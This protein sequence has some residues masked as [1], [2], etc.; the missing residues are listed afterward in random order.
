ML[1]NLMETGTIP[2][3]NLKMD[4]ENDCITL[5][6]SYKGGED[7]DMWKFWKYADENTMHGRNRALHAAIAK[8]KEEVAE[9]PP[10]SYIAKI[11]NLISELFKKYGM[12]KNCLRIS[13]PNGNRYYYRYY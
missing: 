9:V 8:Y 6:S 1:I 13:E 5:L 2:V 10:I 11:L 12:S 3:K 7:F 4:A